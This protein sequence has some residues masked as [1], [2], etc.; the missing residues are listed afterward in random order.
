MPGLDDATLHAYLERL[1]VEARRGEV[2]VATLITLQRAHLA[3]V[4]YE[5]VDIVLGRPPGIDPLAC[6]RRVVAGRGGYCLH[7]NGAFSLLLEELGFEVTH[8]MAGV[9]GRGA[10]VP[11]GPSG[12]HLGV[13]VAFEG[14]RWLVDVGLGDGPSDPLPLEY[15]TYEHHGF[16]FR[17]GASPVA[18]DGWRLDH[19]PRGAFHLVD[20]AGAAA[21]VPADFAA[22]HRKLSTSPESG[23]VRVVAVTRRSGGTLEIL[24]GG[25][26]AK[27]DGMSRRERDI[28]SADEWWGL[29]IDHFGLAYADVPADGRARFWQRIRSAHEAWDAA[30]RP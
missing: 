12:N 21:G 7:L 18:E 10:E 30:G 28:G 25:V 9:W 24:R 26:F 17:L 13:T 29:V 3:A 23:F 27:D 6:A 19:D 8:H 15:G 16:T 14:R 2:D 4:P 22:Q 1:G 11:P 5:N 20:F